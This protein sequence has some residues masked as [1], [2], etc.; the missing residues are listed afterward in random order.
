[1]NAALINVLIAYDLAKRGTAL[2][3]LTGQEGKGASR[4]AAYPP[5]T[6]AESQNDNREM[7]DRGSANR[8]AQL[9]REL[10]VMERRAELERWGFPAGCAVE[11]SRSAL[12]LFAREAK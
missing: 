6:A 4:V 9:T 8:L 5:M 2:A 3:N 12:R 11:I 1:M 10:Q 7:I